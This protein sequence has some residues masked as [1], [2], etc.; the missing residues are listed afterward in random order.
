MPSSET[1]ALTSA[2]ANGVGGHTVSTAA[3][4]TTTDVGGGPTTSSFVVPSSPDSSSSPSSSD[5]KASNTGAI[6]GGV[7]GGVVA[8]A[9]I[10][11]LVFY[12]VRQQSRARAPSAEFAGDGATP[13]PSMPYMAQVQQQPQ[14][15]DDGTTAY[16]PGTPVTPIK[17]YVRFVSFHPRPGF[18]FIFL[19]C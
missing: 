9:I 6:A 10:G 3:P 19:F 13:A 15:S 16:M 7:V 1:T 2:S 12:I 17:L 8:L 18:S 4:A 11:F 14:P 5:G